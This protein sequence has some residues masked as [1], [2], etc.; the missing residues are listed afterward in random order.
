MLLVCSDILNCLSSVGTIVTTE[1][2]KKSIYTFNKQIDKFKSLQHNMLIRMFEILYWY[3]H[4]NVQK[5][6]KRLSE[7]KTFNNDEW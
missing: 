5:L 6:V 3:L 2:Y 1:I 4:S 7:K